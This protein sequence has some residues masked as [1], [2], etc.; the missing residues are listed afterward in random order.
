MTRF[1][2]L[3]LLTLSLSFAACGGKDKAPAPAPAPAPVATMAPEQA[4]IG[5]WRDGS[6]TFIFGADKSFTWQESRPCGAPPCPTTSNRGTYEFRHGKVK[7]V[8]DGNDEMMEFSFNADQTQLNLSSNKRG[9]NW[10]LMR[11]N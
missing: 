11:G 6:N 1:I 8:I 7:V 10:G 5:S 2:G 9:Q 4:L 3:S